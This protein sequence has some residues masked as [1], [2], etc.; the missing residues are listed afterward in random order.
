MNG[1][2]KKKNILLNK[3]AMFCDCVE[4]SLHTMEQ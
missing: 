4:W 3:M 1:M 2:F